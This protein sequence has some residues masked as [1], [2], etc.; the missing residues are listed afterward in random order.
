MRVLIVEDDP[1]LAR[2]LRDGFRD[3]RIEAITAATFGE[4][5][6]RAVF[7]SHDVIILDIMLPGGSGID[8]CRELRDRGIETPIIMLTARDAVDDRVR[9]LDAGADDYLAKP[10]AFRELAA[11]VRALSRRAPAVMSE[12]VE[13]A[14][15]SVDLATRQVTRAGRD[16]ELTAKEFA[17]LE[18]FARHAGHVL[19]RAAIT[20]HVWD[21]NHDPFTNVLEVLVRRL[22]RKIDD[23]FEP[24]LIHTLRGAGYRFGI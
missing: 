12:R 19:D 22:R 10:F 1:E 13:V 3:Q 18:V 14:D 2:A 5:R 9:G 24:K 7:G 16:I 15:L 17:L 23:D 6:E 4:G 11:R 21:E 8:L 20:A